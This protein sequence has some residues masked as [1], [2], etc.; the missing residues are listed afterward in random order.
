MK[1]QFTLVTLVLSLCSM[2]AQNFTRQDSLRG[3]ITPEREW[4][5]LNYYDLHVKVEPEKEFISGHNV[6]RYKVLEA[7]D[8]L[9]IDLQEPMQIASVS[10]DGKKLKFTSEGAAHFI[11]LQKK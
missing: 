5:D 7:S 4:W 9:Q 6:V 3:S 2:S 11:K 8:V 10:Q 1:K